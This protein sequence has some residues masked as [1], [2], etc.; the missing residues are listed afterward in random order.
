[1]DNDRGRLQGQVKK[2]VAI[3]VVPVARDGLRAVV[4]HLTKFTVE[5]RRRE[6]EGA[7]LLGQTS[8][9]RAKEEMDRFTTTVPIRW[10][11]AFY[12]RKKII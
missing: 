11:K 6:T 1:M 8:V 10:E 5:R 7:M 12:T 2:K 4:E 3:P 9:R